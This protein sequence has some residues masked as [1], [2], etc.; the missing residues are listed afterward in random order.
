MK[1]NHRMTVIALILIMMIAALS[2]CGNNSVPG[3]STDNQ[4]NAQQNDDRESGNMAKWSNDALKVSFLYPKGGDVSFHHNK[5]G[6]E[7][8]VHGGSAVAVEC[9]INANQYLDNTPFKARVEKDFQDNAN[10]EEG[11]QEESRKFFEVDGYPAAFLH[12]K[13]LRGKDYCHIIKLVTQKGNFEYEFLNM[14]FEGSHYAESEALATEITDSFHLMKGMVNLAA[15][16]V[17]ESGKLAKWS[18]QDLQVSFLYPEGDKVS[19]KKGEVSID[20]TS[21][22]VR[23]SFINDNFGR[24][25]NEIVEKEMQSFT[26]ILAAK[27]GYKE[28]SR[29]LYEIDGYPAAVIDYSVPKGNE[30]RHYLMLITAN[31]GNTYN[32]QV[33]FA[34]ADDTKY[35]AMAT[36]IINSF[37][38]LKG[39]PN[40]EAFNAK[41]G[42]SGEVKK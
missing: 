14:F 25:E 10:N 3:G 21:S 38:F 12:Y 15:V 18:N 40:L 7:V 42:N 32:L 37:H 17:R 27:P 8:A 11:Y 1:R 33:T 2:G 34:G 36:K 22:T 29:K 6:A 20:G 23:L 13:T 30:D 4:S 35:E 16:D 9:R 41:V 39:D 31:F 19:V 26:S 24:T 28:H 5:Y